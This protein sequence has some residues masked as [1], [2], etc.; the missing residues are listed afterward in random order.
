MMLQTL[1]LILTTL[2]PVTIV[3][4]LMFFSL[5]NRKTQPKTFKPTTLTEQEIFKL[6]QQT[7]KDR[8]DAFLNQKVK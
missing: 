1:L 6:V 3:A 7:E 2:M 4:T 8:E 5:K